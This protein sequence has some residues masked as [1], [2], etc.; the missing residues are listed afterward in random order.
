MTRLTGIPASPGIAVGPARVLARVS[1]DF[2]ET[3]IE[4]AAREA[5]LARFHRAIERSVSEV[6]AVRAAAEKKLRKEES[7][8]F[9]AHLMMLEDPALLDGVAARVRDESLCA[10][11]AVAAVV[12]QFAGQFESMDDPYF[13][14]RAADVRDIGLR[15]M[16]NLKQAE[17]AAEGGGRGVLV[18]EELLP[19]DTVGLDADLVA[20]I[21][22]E[23]GGATSHASILAR[24]LGIPCVVGVEG[25]LANV[26]AGIEIAMD[27]KTG[28][29]HINPDE[30]TRGLLE[31]LASEMKSKKESAI[32]RKSEPAVATDG[33][34]ILVFA[35]AGSAEDVAAAV[36]NGAEGIG[37]FRTE[38]L[39]LD[40]RTM[41]S[42]E[43]Q[44]AAY[45]AAA[46]AAGGRPVA[47]RLLDI[48]GDK[49]A[50]YL[51][52]PGEMN[53]FLGLRAVRLLLKRP[54]VLKAQ[55]RA[56]LRASDAGDVSILVPMVADVSELEAVREIAESCRSELERE[57][58][59]VRRVPIG[60]MIEVPA[61][62]LCAKRLA[63][64]A[65]Y[66][67]VGTNDLTQYCMAV[68][69]GNAAVA[70]LYRP[71]HPAVMS[72]IRSAAAAAREAGIKISVCGEAA[73]DENMIPLLLCAGVDCLS[74]A[75][76]AVPEVKE[77]VRS[78]DPH[79]AAEDE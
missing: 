32:R 77:Y 19:S 55:I 3:K 7:E 16:K 21:A 43:E 45:R 51:E 75:P 71:D 34:R 69:R 28:E 56:V 26:R 23:K 73:S 72:L 18:A 61:A 37:L 24:S 59:R 67:S 6:G 53:P 54:E 10:E 13:R 20:G 8:I 50:K 42:E 35:N 48:G 22:T 68:D 9:S 79:G 5:E 14:E 29:V 47:I 12:R 15:V 25:L 33:R 76:K 39:F 1:L 46:E 58:K 31:K 74:V 49:P 65:D 62:A 60:I 52:I 44:T 36:S 17:I 38:F 66:F 4:E 41:P 57:G 30:K 40:R 27:G 64:R 70:H 78:A 63:G 11:S 2:P